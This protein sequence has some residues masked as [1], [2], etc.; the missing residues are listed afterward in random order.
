MQFTKLKN[1]N[2]QLKDI[3]VLYRSNY[4]SRSIED[5]LASKAIPYKMVGGQKFYERE[6]I[7]NC[8]AFLRCIYKPTDISLK[9]IINVPS[10]KLGDETLKK[11]IHFPAYMLFASF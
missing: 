1:N 11:L 10:R 4:Y 3:V 7:K 6:E 2:Y 5:L 9:R 8:L